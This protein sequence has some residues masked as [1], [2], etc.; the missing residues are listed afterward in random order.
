M[1]KNYLGPLGF[2]SGTG[3]S[4]RV[5]EASCPAS[6]SQD[7]ITDSDFGN[8][9]ESGS[10]RVIEQGGSSPGK[11]TSCDRGLHKFIV[12]SAK[13]GWGESPCSESE[14]IKSIHNIR[15]LQNGRDSY[16]KRPFKTGGLVSKNRPQGCLFNCTHLDKSSEIPSFPVEGQHARVCLSPLRFSFC[17]ESVHKVDETSGSST[18]TAG[19]S[20]NNLF[21]RHINY[22]RILRPSPPSGSFNPESSRRFRFHS[23]LQEI[24][25]GSN[26]GD[27]ISGFDSKLQKPYALLTRRKAEKN[28]KTVQTV[29]RNR[30][31]ADKRVVK[32][33]RAL[34]LFYSSHIP[35]PPPLQ[36][37]TAVKKSGHDGTSIIRC[38][39]FFRPGGQ[40]GGYLVEGSPSGME[41]QSTFPKTYRSPHRDRRLSK[42]LGGI[43]PRYKYR[44][45]LV[46]RRKASS[47]QLFGTT[48]RVFRDPDIYKRQSLR[49]C[50]TANGQHSSSS[51]HKQDGRNSLSG[52]F[53]SSFTALGVVPAK[54]L[55]DICSTSTRTFKCQSRPRIQNFIGFQRL[56]TRPHD[57]SVTSGEMGTLGDRPLCIPADTPAPKVC[58]L[59]TRPLSSA[60]RCIFN[61]LERHSG[62]CL[63]P[64]CSD[65][66]L[67]TAGKDT[68]CGTSSSGGSSVACTDL[69]PTLTTSVHRASSVI[70]NIT[71]TGDERQ[72]VSS[73]GQPTT[74]WMET[75]RQR[76][77]AADIS[78]ATR[79]LLLAAWRRNTTSTYASA[80]NKWVGWCDRRQVNPLSAPLSLILEFLKD[81]FEE[82]KAYRTLN[83]YRSTLS[84]LLPEID[85]FK[86][87]SHPLV[88][89]LLKGA[90]NLRPPEPRY[91]HTWSVGKVL[92]FIKSLGPNK[93]L[94]IKVLSYKLVVLLGLTA[95]DRS[96]DLAKRD[97]RFRSFHPEGVSFCLVPGLTKTSKPGDSPKCSFHAAF[98]LDKSLCPVECLR[99]YEN[100]TIDFRPK[101]DSLP[102]PL[103]LSF[104]R[105]HKPVCSS[106]LARWIKSFLFL[107][108][109]DTTIFSAHS[110][111]GAATS[112]ALFQ[113]VSV[114]EILSMADWSQESTFRK[115][116][117][118]P[119]FNPA[120]GKAVLSSSSV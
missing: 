29:A 110:L 100:R 84:A 48:S 111:R 35:S 98:P 8:S 95:P 85:S 1:G 83:V 19:H 75:I 78:E 58:Q 71:Q 44:G 10:S 67:S 42:R 23:K 13:K 57:V 24:P 36:E 74:G 4:N 6:S 50:E 14:A 31:P 45:P 113:G 63:P 33:P 41:W 30:E 94:D 109:I 88:S 27:R 21:R 26:S 22:G 39:D 55:G 80:W 117:Y 37:P 90:F 114:S 103:F 96:S 115:F 32:V 18:E 68:E 64:L 43:L 16:V 101:N 5:Y 62:V 28:S 79:N 70:S 99:S 116:Y 38:H 118:K 54:Q 12:C 107:S 91:S 87:G 105:P 106:S 77:E 56:E 40:R 53:K 15:T 82:G 3:I 47:H 65:R 25:F 9:V 73:S 61:E 11:T 34:N 92:D 60:F 2:T 17:S 66:A 93:D 7:P 119:R 76:Y 108:G 20:A 102:N 81:Q 97:L 89:Q 72:S 104:I 86:V 51:L 112:T 49:S 52:S 59:E 69:V 46:L 120:P